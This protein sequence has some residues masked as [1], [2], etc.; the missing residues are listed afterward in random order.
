MIIHELNPEG[1]EVVSMG[2]VIEAATI[3]HTDLRLT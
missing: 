2:D 3:I 1:R